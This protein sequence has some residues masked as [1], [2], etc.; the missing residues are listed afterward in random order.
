M[1]LKS[2][3]I[4]IQILFL[5]SQFYCQFPEDLSSIDQLIYTN[6][7]SK[8]EEVYINSYIDN[9]QSLTI[10]NELHNGIRVLPHALI[11]NPNTIGCSIGA[12][13]ENDD[14]LW[15]FDNYD[16]IYY[17]SSYNLV[18][19]QCVQGNE[20]ILDLSGLIRSED[21]AIT[22][23]YGSF[24][25]FYFWIQKDGTN[26]ITFSCSDGSSTPITFLR[27]YSGL[28]Q[29]YLKYDP[30]LNTFSTNDNSESF[31][32]SSM[33]ISIKSNDNIYFH[34][35]KLTLLISKETIASTNCKENSYKCPYSYYCDSFTGECKKCLGMFSQCSDRK[36]G[37]SCSTFT[38]EWQN[39]G[40]TQRN[41]KEDYY[42]LQ[43]INDMS[44]DIVPAIRSN[45]ASLS[46]W[47]FTTKDFNEPSLINQYN[48]KL[49]HIT[50]EDF[51]VVTVIPGKTKYTIYVTGYEMYHEAYGTVIKNQETKEDFENNVLNKFPYKNW[52]T[53]IE[54]T[55]INRWIN[56][57]V[58]YN[59][60]LLRLSIQA[61][62]K[63]SNSGSGSLSSN[64]VLLPGEYIY[65]IDDVGNPNIIKESRL[66]YKKYYRD[67]DT[68]Q[69]NF[70]IYNNDIGVYLRKL[71]VFA[72]ELLV[73]TSSTPLNSDS[74]FGFQYTEFEKVFLID[75]SA[76]PELILA[77]PFENITKSGSLEENKYFVEYYIY[78]MTKVYNNM[79]KKYLV[80]Y[81][82]DIEE[83]LYTYSPGLYRL[84]LIKKN[85]FFPDE[86]L[87]TPQAITSTD[88][89]GDYCYY[90][91]ATKKNPYNCNNGYL[92]NPATRQCELI[93][94]L[95]GGSRTLVAGINSQNNMK[96]TLTNI[97]Y[98][99]KNANCKAKI[100]LI[101]FECDANSKK[102]F[103]A[104]VDMNDDFM[105]EDFIGYFYY[106]YFFNLPPI[107][108]NLQN[109]YHNYYIQFNFLYETNTALRPKD[110]MKGKKLYLFYSDAF[111]IWHDY[112]MNYL[113]VE[114]RLGNS[115]KNLIPN[116]NTENENLFTISVNKDKNNIY[117]GKIYINGV[118]IYMPPFTAGA[119]SYILFCHN[120]TA[121]PVGN[122]VFW[123]GGF[124]NQLKIYDLEDITL[125]NDNSFYDLYIYNNYYSYYNYQNSKQRFND[126]K[127]NE[128]IDM[129]MD[130]I[131]Y[132]KISGKDILNIDINKDKLQMFNYG[133]D[134]ALHLNN[135]KYITSGFEES[136]TCANNFITNCY[137]S[138]NIFSEEARVCSDAKYFKYDNCETFPSSPKD[139]YFSLTLPLINDYSITEINLDSELGASSLKTLLTGTGTN[140]I[141]VGKVTYTFWIKLIGFKDPKNIFKI[142]EDSSI[143]CVL[144][145]QEYNKLILQCGENAGYNYYQNTYAILPENYG[146]YMHISIALSMHSRGNNYHDKG[147]FISFQINRE[148]IVDITTNALNSAPFLNIKK[149]TLYTEIFAQISK[150][151]IYNEALIGGYAFNTNKYYNTEIP[152]AVRIID[153]SRK[154][155]LLNHDYDC[156]S[157]YDPVLNDDYYENTGY[158]S[159]K[160][161]YLTK[162]NMYKKKQCSD[163]C[164][165]TCYETGDNNCACATNSYFDYIFK[166]QDNSY[167]C[168]KLPYLDFKRY[169]SSSISLNNNIKGIDFWYFATEGVNVQNNDLFK[170]T[171]NGNSITS[172]TI[173]SPTIDY[174]LC[175]SH[176][177]TCDVENK[178]TLEN[179]CH[180]SCTLNAYCTS[181][182][183]ENTEIDLSSPGIM[184]IRQF[185]VW[186]SDFPT[187][188]AEEEIFHTAYINNIKKTDLVL[189][190]IDSLIK[191]DK[192]FT[193]FPKSYSINPE[194]LTYQEYF[195]YSPIE[196]EIPELNLCLESEE[197]KDIINL[198]GIDDIDLSD[199]FHSVTGRYTMELWIKLINLPK[200]LNGI[201]IIWENHVS[202]SILTD[203]L[204]N[205]LSI[206]CFPQDY[207]S[208]PKNKQGREI[209]DLAKDA[210]NKDVI[211]IDLND[212]ENDWI[213]LRCAYSWDNEIFYLKSD[214]YN[215]NGDEQELNHEYASDGRVVDY[216]F[217]YLFMEYYKYH[218][219]IQNANLNSESEIYI[220]NLYLFNEYLP[221]AYD[222]K[223]VLFTGEEHQVRWITLKIDFFNF[224]K[225]DNED[226]IVLK[227]IRKVNHNYK[228]EQ[229]E[230]INIKNSDKYKS[231]GGI[232]LDDVLKGNG[233]IKLKAVN[234]QPL[235]CGE[236]LYLSFGNTDNSCED[237][238]K[239][240]YNVGPGGIL[241]LDQTVSGLCNYKLDNL[242][243]YTMPYN[244]NDNMK[245][246]NDYIRVGFKCFAPETQLNSAIYFNRC[247]N[248]YP[249]YASFSSIKAQMKQ[250]YIFEISFMVDLI[251]EFCSKDG[252]EERYLLWAQPH[253]IYLD[254]NDVF[255]YKDIN[256][257]N[258][259]KELP[260][261][262]LFE[263]NHVIIEFNPND[264]EIKIYINYDMLEPAL[265]YNIK[266]EDI[267][268]YYLA[269]ID[270]CQ[271]DTE[272]LCT[273]ITKLTEINW[274]A[275]Y[276]SRA[277][278][279]SLKYSSIYMVYEHIRNKFIYNSDSILVQYNFSTIGNDLNNFHDEYGNIDL[280]FMENIPLVS[281]L[282]SKDNTL[283][284]GSTGNFD[285]GQFHSNIYTTS[286]EPKSGKF[287]Y[288]D[289]YSGC[290]RC[291]SSEKN[292]CYQCMEGYELF[293]RQC[294]E[295]TG[296]YYQL[297]NYNDQI[298]EA[299]IDTQ[300]LNHNPLTITLWVKYYGLIKGSNY[301][302]ET[303]SSGI[304]CPM[305]IKFSTDDDI[306]ICHEQNENNLL[307]YLGENILFSDT[308]FLKELGTWQL[309]SVSN[310]KCLYGNENTCNF[311]PSIFSLAINGQTVS[312]RNSNNIPY[313]GVTLNKLLFGYGIIMI[314]GDIRI[315]KTFIL[316]PLGVITNYDSYEN[317]LSKSIKFYGSTSTKCIEQKMILSSGGRDM[318][319]QQ[320]E[321]CKEDYN[322]YHNLADFKCNSED[323]MIDITSID[324]ECVNCISECEHCGGKTK[325]NCSCY[326][327]DKYWFRNDKNTNRLYC[328]LVPYLDLN[329]YSSLE[330]TEIKY[331]TTN[332]YAIEFWYFIYEY[333]KDE[334]HFYDQTIS[335]ENHVKIEFTKYTNKEVKIECYPL[336]ER[337]ESIFDNDVTQEFF[338]WNHVICATD[339]NNKL[340]YLN[341]R[342][343]NNI[344]GEGVKQMNYSTYDN[345]RV[346]LKFESLNNM[347][348]T[349]SNG[350]F[351]IKELKLWNF[352]SVREFDTKC[353]YN[354]EW[355]KNNDIPNILHYFPFKM[356]KEGLIQD[357][358]GNTPTIANKENNG[359]IGYNIIDY[360]NEINIDEEFPECLIV[361]ALPQR[362]YYNLTNV[363]IYNYEIEPQTYPYY[364]YKYESYISE[365]GAKSYND[366]TRAELK[367]KDNP[368]EL[369]ISKFKESNYKN[370]QLNIYLTLTEINTSK[371]HYGFTIIK[372]NE[373]YPGLDLIYKTNGMQDNL[374]VNIDDLTTKYAFTDEEIW[375]R[376]KL[377]SSL[378]DIHSMALNDA[379][380]TTTF[381][382][383]EYSEKLS[384][385]YADNIVVKNPVC[386]NNFC[387]GRGTCVIIVRNM[388]C[389]CYEGYAGSNCQITLTNKEYVSETNLKM[390]NFLTNM[391]E[392]YT[393]N[394]DKNYLQQITYLVKSSTMFDD[395][396]NALIQ[397][398]FNFLDYIKVNNFDLLMGENEIKLIFDT[399]SYILI[400]MYHDIQQFRAKNYFAQGNVKYST[401]SKIPEVD[402]TYDQ[403]DAIYDLSN[404][405]TTIIPELILYLIRINKGDI[406]QNEH[407]YTAFDFSV[408]SCSHGFDYIEYFQMTY[409]NNRDIYNS[410]LPYIDAYKCADYIFGSTGYNTIFL[411]LLN[412]HYDPLSFHPQYSSSA[413]YSL[414]VFYATEIGEK[415]DIKACP[416]FIDIYFPLTLYNNS[417]IEFINSHTKF[418]GENEENKYYDINDPYVT[419]PVYVNKDGTVSRKSRYDRINE[420]LPMINLEC[421]Y[422]NSKL[423]LVSKITST[424]VSDNF[425]LV[426]QTH[427]LSFYTIQSQSSKLEYTKAGKF[428]Y[429]GA[430]RVFLCGDNWGNGC[431]VLIIII[432]VIFSGFIILFAFLEKTLMITK[433]SLNNIKLE[434]LKQN[435]L[436]LDEVELIEEITKV[437]K[438][439]QQ[440]NMERNL[441]INTDKDKI[442]KDL[443]ENLYLYGTKNVDY[444][445]MAFKDG[446][447]EKDLEN[448]YGGKGVFS[449]PPKKRKSKSK[450]KDKH[451]MNTGFVIDDLYEINDVSDK[452]DEKEK[453]TNIKQSMNYIN[454]RNQK[455]KKR[456]AKLK[457][458]T[459]DN[460]SDN[461]NQFKNKRYYHVK[462]YN[463]EKKNEIDKYNYN[464][465]KDSDFG[466]NESEGSEENKQNNIRINSD[467]NS[468]KDSTE[469][470]RSKNDSKKSKNEE[471]IKGEHDDNMNNMHDNDDVDSD[472][473]E[474]VDYFSKYKSV[475]KNENRKG[476]KKVHVQ[477]G[478]YT[479]VDKYR[480]VTFVREKIH[481][482]NLPDFFEQ[483]NKKDPNLLIF[484]FNL[485]LRRDIYIS[486]FMV[487]STINPRW[488]RILCLY[489][490]I[491]LQFLFLTFAMTLGEEADITK[492][493]K[494]FSYQLIN[495]FISD[496]VMLAFIPF[497][498][499]STK[500]K[501]TLFLNLKSTQQM[502]LLKTFKEV[503]ETQKRKLKF[504][505]GIMVATFI[506]TFYFNFNYCVVLYDSR[507]TFAGC[508]LVGVVFDCF[509]YEGVLNG[510]IVLL[511]YLKKK[512][513]M[514]EKPYRYLFELRNYRN[515]F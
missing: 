190:S 132:N 96:G 257:M 8:E 279:Y 349:A 374:E 297:N 150:F 438:M 348:D 288:K 82:G 229:S 365:K 25:I 432:F 71:Y 192:K 400:N 255:Y 209:I 137:G 425:Y 204:K 26:V 493:G 397:N 240:G 480:K 460:D 108:F 436:I 296:Y 105:G 61:F 422:Y 419:W 227:Y 427:H 226:K 335:W 411:V 301:A 245:C 338:K 151:Y 366:I 511:Y 462:E 265:K 275:A 94:N 205:K 358:K 24:Y 492:G 188:G 200:L 163:K 259:K 19:G 294:R 160:R 28:Y 379:N 443:K 503:K 510:A 72:T 171:I 464:M 312:R 181:I 386:N 224:V 33:S 159:D 258:E 267:N 114:D 85:E 162:N 79:N 47:L 56:V 31:T 43:Y 178:P 1:N 254:K 362:I 404:K 341:E 310:Y 51:F 487:S 232:F 187:G 354:Y 97:C 380:T 106:S 322:I 166:D 101:D 3:F 414:D 299:Q 320:S 58:S 455:N 54:V 298:L 198:S 352:F 269:N 273:K 120:D 104:C 287:T 406:A 127:S 44:Y 15:D 53:K 507:W 382:N 119:I 328:Q 135:Q 470:L 37:I 191:P 64:T 168:R 87:S 369:F 377:F 126:Y 393:L 225:I 237:E 324:N 141:R 473:V 172:I 506:I 441:K 247:Y 193:I 512:K 256:N 389:N 27:P 173:K 453:E 292:E 459:Q 248:I 346:H 139:K 16:K 75:N 39:V 177:N 361:F 277:A 117:K 461:E 300:Y 339:L 213:Y 111:R 458:K 314:L 9:S 496:I 103:D 183:L 376:L 325:L 431:S 309:I 262:S 353:I 10:K 282:R 303:T 505:I 50:L 176:I 434:I 252:I 21:I 475:I 5:F 201:N 239:D 330:F 211:N 98:E 143:S 164:G 412:Y 450:K 147:F 440:D 90:N 449:N 402:L 59:K 38:R 390:W 35:L 228:E 249:V 283:L 212:K 329:K 428:F 445:E 121:C 169:K 95:V 485:F 40:S 62:Y 383:Y 363:L 468:L 149:F 463:P 401:D 129:K 278:I 391:N 175:N 52:N 180:I 340:Y 199:I 89:N 305:L 145:Y 29:F 421:N 122:D 134:Q 116:F 430:P 472:G 13:S 364:N 4:I 502:Q 394:I 67:T 477:N 423:G 497:F 48:P 403:I 295:I 509:L 233:N 344:I 23:T 405:I 388:V 471:K 331:A 66:H 385:Y 63:K 76:M 216:P 398:F 92:I 77:V 499:I 128:Q 415:L 454:Q 293:N 246:A 466:F 321:Q 46:F 342:K 65:N 206:Y 270:F 184:L 86:L 154:K 152:I 504:I 478:N 167:Q 457:P 202:I 317:Y 155:C 268:N 384:S 170:I 495:I 381:L 498:R 392:F 174:T 234:G 113:G 49:I 189:L 196:M 157:D 194:P 452:E 514:F 34:R 241:D 315:Y 148:N 133:I 479:I 387:S 289:C 407:N 435:R 429:L 351:L 307:M 444:N 276:Y 207:L 215:I 319:Y 326:Y 500:D 165:S 494:V 486:P 220:R 280:N 417:E 451:V 219:Y 18:G 146:K 490:Y 124:Y 284:F 266:E 456:K 481:Y 336:N 36:S 251:N 474:N 83:Y 318:F 378:G 153:D 12:Y 483:I 20:I 11:S 93:S 420:V 144:I 223:N 396:Y 484:F 118:K 410:Y 508:F 513:K 409:K 313:R 107:K 433:S 109:T 99:V 91:D 78:D 370:V 55:K 323:K 261:L 274:G 334:I 372:I 355:S 186:I 304:N 69:L 41:C 195:G 88:P 112:S 489:M 142:G 123:T 446:N 125:L 197:C 243:P 2:I 115:H 253:A 491:L 357:I 68:T 332:E 488:K 515:C 337:D 359:Y 306:Y 395:S 439:N 476:G 161:V 448:N 343:V 238:C 45:A 70:K 311:Y 32:C 333:T 231:K 214:T 469:Q 360:D 130:E 110:K 286:V 371:K 74:L 413:S 140:Y 260:Q 136:N 22:K 501:K 100:G 42:N 250:G 368:R 218:V 447:K 30:N 235:E 482:I 367:T 308:A 442:D 203:T 465:Y 156:I 290:K 158:P 217:K 285:Y 138:S 182:K 17:P 356:D 244:Y 221:N 131:L 73:P 222:T 271:G 84:N 408:K 210:L 467:I 291:Y 418:L 345:R 236:N 416:N 208:S 230:A 281:P 350:V 302:Y 327:N 316:N 263:W 7:T 375:N 424:S 80:I 6:P 60:N 179:W 373:Y 102:I 185:K 399:I 81:P 437:N 272:N 14:E 264:L 242:H 347:G 426:C 57:I